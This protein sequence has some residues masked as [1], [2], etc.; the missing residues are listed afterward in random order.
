MRSSTGIAR[1]AGE[2]DKLFGS[3]TNGDIAAHL[4]LSEG[5]VK[6]HVNRAMAKLGARDRAQLV[7]LAHDP[8]TSGGLLVACDAGSVDAVMALFARHGFDEHTAKLL[9]PVAGGV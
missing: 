7:V 1:Q 5:T 3:V 4:F 8:Q 2:D 9:F 6:T